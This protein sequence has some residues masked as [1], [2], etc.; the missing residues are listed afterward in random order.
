MKKIILLLQFLILTGILNAQK[1][2]LLQLKNGSLIRGSIEELIP[3]ESVRITDGCG[4]SWV[5]RLDDVE[6]ISSEVT[7]EEKQE[8]LYSGFRQGLVNI[9]SIGVLA[10]SVRNEQP[11]PFS[12]QST[13]GWRHNSGMFFG[14][15]AGIEFIGTTFCPLF[16]DL[17]YDFKGEAV[18]PCL[19][20]RA[21]YALPLQGQISQYGA[22]Y[23][24]SGGVLG[25]VGIGLK[26]RNRTGLAWDLSMLYRYQQISYSLA[27]DYQ[28]F[29]STYTENYNRVELRVGLYID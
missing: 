12:I 24:Y 26:I 18:T 3:G 2:D 4:N 22:N 29:M 23:R 14:A 25:A 10:G 6:R 8:P 19:I 21:G 9:T 7:V 1:T 27:Y 28:S 15:G 16:A 20:G 5:Y 13:V 11:A 17:R